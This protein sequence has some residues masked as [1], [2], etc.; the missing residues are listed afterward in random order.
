[1]RRTSL[2][3][4][5]ALALSFAL[6]FS[7]GA[8][9]SVKPA[10][11]AKVKE[12]KKC[13]TDKQC[14]GGQICVEGGCRVVRDLR[15]C[16]AA[17]DC[18]PTEVCKSDYCLAAAEFAAKKPVGKGRCQIDT[19]CAGGRVCLNQSCVKAR[20]ARAEVVPV[21]ANMVLVPGGTFQMGFSSADVDHLQPACQRHKPE[22]S[23]VYFEDAP[24]RQV[25]V[26]SFYVDRTEVTVADYVRF[27]NELGDHQSGCGGHACA[28]VTSEKDGARVH[29]EG[30]TYRAVPGLESHPVVN[31]SWWGADSFCR[32]AG[33]RL[34]TEAE[35]EKA[36]RGTD[37][38][39]WPWGN[40]D[41]T[42][43]HA[44]YANDDGG[45]ASLC[46]GSR[47]PG[48]EPD[49]TAPVGSY[50]LDRS[51]F[52][53]VDMAGNVQEW[54]SDW[55]ETAYYGTAPTQDPTGPTTGDRKVRRGASWGHFPT[56]A[57]ASFRDM[58]SADTMGDLIGFRCARPLE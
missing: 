17:S 25:S 10:H 43:A 26:K 16:S 32:W 4:G 42:C 39:Y 45:D 31:V 50:P 22:C 37:G 18:S 36:A 52:G 3:L 23:R 34:P 12:P 24:R 2:A 48:V 41:V 47:A 7:G 49:S 5:A 57:L 51:P 21:S 28:A 54:V 35:W 53:A 56:Y 6:L 27:L 44:L 58:T 38:R 13:K 20:D 30:K 1:M 40:Q 11:A 9:P 8:P 15:R 14:R 46:T 33:K 19:D 29:Y 55:Y